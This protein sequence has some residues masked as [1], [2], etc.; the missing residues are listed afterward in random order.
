MA[1]FYATL[2]GI[3]FTLLGLWWVVVQMKYELWM[4]TPARRRVAYAASMHFVAPGLIALIAVL[5]GEE[6]Q[7]WRLGAALGGVLG[8]AVSGYALLSVNLSR[9]QRLQEGLICLL[10]LIA[11]GL[12]F[13]TTPLFGVRPVMIE[14]LV[15]TAVLG[16][17]VQFVWDCFTE[18]DTA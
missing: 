18:R 6:S 11:T 10:F 14:A 4:S 5:S 2:A 17:G 13:V 1:D 16:L 12:A 3:A 7:I 15:D 8:A 9:S